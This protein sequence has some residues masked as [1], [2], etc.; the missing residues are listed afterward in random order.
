MLNPNPIDPYPPKKPKLLGQPDATT[1][2][3][4]A[5]ARPA[6]AAPKPAV[7]SPLTRLNAEIDANKASQD[8][9][10]GIQSQQQKIPIVAPLIREGRSG[11]TSTR[12]PESE[13][14]V[15]ANMTLGRRIADEKAG[16]EARVPALRS[17]TEQVKAQAAQDRA[18]AA[19]GAANKLLTGVGVA[20]IP[21]IARPDFTNVVGGSSTIQSPSPRTQSQLEQASRD[22]V[23]AR[24]E[25]RGPG[26]TGGA[27]AA[28]TT[29]SGYFEGSNGRRTINA[30]GSIAGS[31]TPAVPISRPALGATAQADTSGFAGREVASTFGLGVD[32]PRIDDQRATIARPTGS[33]RGPDAM[34]EHYAHKEDREALAKMSSSIDSQIFA[35]S[36]AAQR[37]EPAAIR[38]ISDLNAQKAGLLSGQAQ[39]SDGAIQGRENR[40]NRLQVT[41]AEQ[42]GQDRRTDAQIRL[43]DR[44][45]ASAYDMA[46]LEDGTKREAIAADIARPQFT[47]DGQG[48]YVSVSGAI[49]RPVLDETGKPMLA[50][51]DKDRGDITPR[52]QYASLND[53]LSS[54][55]NNPPQFQ[56]QS[57]GH[58]EQVATL[59]QQ[60]ASLEKQSREAGA[61]RVTSIAEYNK[62]PK[63]T[64]Y[65]APD[66]GVYTKP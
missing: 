18:T 12:S 28:P 44:N 64:R 31:A 48:R 5:L 14:S 46:L 27:I 47:T 6:I 52:D 45:A 62:L 39:L 51:P 25:L 11:W 41:G 24:H 15:L 57:A 13:A 22:E 43:G 58:N 34:G 16:Q 7:Q 29:A 36:L 66:G 23:V 53:Q 56:D 54:L 55:L 4:P 19:R 2:T 21:Q 40:D 35:F 3:A 17:L 32:D 10:A 65:L 33:F 60:I 37:G 9:I 38:A 61:T 30:D 63:G 42:E 59:R 1:S 8:R 26:A 50:K 49:A 20:P